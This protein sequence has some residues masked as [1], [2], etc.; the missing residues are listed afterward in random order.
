MRGL[1]GRLRRLEQAREREEQ[2]DVRLIWGSE[3]DGSAYGID[4]I[5]QGAER[6]SVSWRQD[7][8]ETRPA[9]MAPPPEKGQGIG[10]TGQEEE[11]EEV[12]APVRLQIE[13]PN[14]PDP[15]LRDHRKKF[16]KPKK[17]TPWDEKHE[18]A[19]AVRKGR[20]G[21]RYTDGGERWPLWKDG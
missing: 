6:R 5:G 7:D 21:L 1:A 19:T 15:V 10:D 11:L 16:E 13:E 8:D 17:G 20:P 4:L 2:P 12:R 18:L 9:D 3:E 14:E